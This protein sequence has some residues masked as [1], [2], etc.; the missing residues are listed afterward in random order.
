MKAPVVTRRPIRWSVV[1]VALSVLTRPAEGIAQSHCSLREGPGRAATMSCGDGTRAT[2]RSTGREVVVQTNRGDRVRGIKVGD[3]WIFSNQRGALGRV[4]HSEG[5]RPIFSDRAGNT[6]RMDGRPRD[7][8]TIEREGGVATR[9]EYGL[10]A[11]GEGHPAPSWV[12]RMP[13]LPY[14]TLARPQRTTRP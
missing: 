5:S 7:G 13:A 3:A 9:L 6:V 10:S 1:L 12:S 8:R 14:R 4:R 11:R 2:I